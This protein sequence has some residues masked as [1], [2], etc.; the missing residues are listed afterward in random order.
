M[1]P[2]KRIHTSGYIAPKGQPEP[3]SDKLIAFVSQTVLASEPHRKR[4]KMSLEMRMDEQ[5]PEE[6]NTREGAVDFI[7]VKE[8]TWEIKC[9]GSKMADLVVRRQNIKPHIA[10]TGSARSHD[11]AIPRHVEIKDDDGELLNCLPLPEVK[12][13]IAGLHDVYTAL[14]IHTNGGDWAK[15]QGRVYVE[16]GVSLF[17][18]EESDYI[19][20]LKFALNVQHSIRSGRPP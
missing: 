12:E 5:D 4:Q 13:G 20:M 10:C 11:G 6:P 9:P 2:P 17:Q 18:R 19:G 3:I 1:A 14:Y 16:F 8:A 7:V 15:S